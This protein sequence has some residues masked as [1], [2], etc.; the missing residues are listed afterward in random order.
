MPDNRAL[1]DVLKKY[2]G[3]NEFRPL[4]E[5]II[6]SIIEGKDTL[7]IMPT[8]G[9]KS[10]CFQVP[11]VAQ[12]GICIVVSP[13]IALMKDQIDALNKK[14][15]KSVAIYSGLSYREIDITLDNCIY[16]DYKFLYVS[17]ERLETNIFIE[18]IKKMKVNLVAVDEAHCI[19]QW[20]YDFR[21]SYLKI[22]SIR[23]YLHN[24]PILALTATATEKVKWDIQDKLLFESTNV[25]QKSFERPNLKYLVRNEESK[26]KKM[27]EIFSKTEGSALVYVRSRKK[28]TDIANY[29][30]RNG[31]KSDYYH[32]GLP[33]TLREN[34][35]K[36]W[37]QDEIRVMV[38][39]N[40]FGMG[41]D[42]P[43]VRVVVHLDIPESIEA[44]Y[45][46][47]G[48]A[49]RDDK[50]AYAVLL[51]SGVDVRL[52]NDR[53]ENS[54][55]DV[56]TIRRVYDA[57]GNYFQLA[58]GAGEGQNFD[59]DLSSF[60]TNYQLSKSEA[61]Y[62]LK[63]LEHQGY[64]VLSDAVFAKSRLKILVVKSDL[65]KLQVSNPKYEL[66]IRQLLR[67]Y[68][69]IFDEYVAIEEDQ[70][71]KYLS[72]EKVEV[73][74]MLSYLNS[75][76]IISYQPNKELPQLTYLLPRLSSS[77][78]KLDINFYKERRNIE[79]DKYQ[80]ILNYAIQKDVCRSI[81][82]ANYFG[83]KELKPCEKCDVCVKRRH[84]KDNE[85]NQKI[86][87]I[88]KQKLMNKPLSISELVN[89][90]S[91]FE[92]DHIIGQVQSLKERGNIIENEGQ[93]LEWKW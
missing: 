93:K 53:L 85:L 83:E 36:Q 70:L 5:D 33:I 37:I 4:Q 3:Y 13:L 23:A 87:D 91:A 31:I 66:L 74:K 54:F 30:S 34:K 45:Q 62:S 84:S 29:L 52:L 44:Y 89:E 49:G 51:Y 2:W 12:E 18:R 27:L 58:V 68:T 73:T 92:S 26:L 14:G 71:V 59:F 56:K 82:I 63:F 28:T 8:G 38:C 75:T 35:Q 24:I 76:N 17:P 43:D 60:A 50:E 90:L 64:L 39:T 42:K 48:R 6:N 20:G 81:F 41:V 9:G 55:A 25:F 10:I 40:A 72:L 15:I 61:Y 86:V 67:F 80:Q 21:P 11:G 7:A 47:A 57:L 1:Q 16:G 22:A 88:I 46:E 65:Y 78:L 77:N 32:A 19:S 79:E 69:G